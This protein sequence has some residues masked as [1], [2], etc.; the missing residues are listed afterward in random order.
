MTQIKRVISG[1]ETL[2]RCACNTV[3]VWKLLCYA[4][5]LVNPQLASASSTT[6][7]Q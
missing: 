5:R 6:K 4:I 2:S 1:V 7:L 3:K